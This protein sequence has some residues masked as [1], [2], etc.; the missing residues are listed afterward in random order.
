MT[1]SAAIAPGAPSP[2]RLR[3]LAIVSAVSVFVAWQAL[4]LVAGDNRAGDP[5]VPGPVDV[6]SAA[7]KLG[8]YWQGGLGIER[9]DQ[10]GELTWAGAALAFAYHSLVTALRLVVGFLI[11][12]VTGVVLAAL[13]SWSDTLR[14][15]VSL[16]AHG[17]RMLPLL[18]MIPLF[19][20]WFGNSNEGAVLFIGFTVFTFIFV[21]TITA[22]ANVPS[23]FP[24]YGQALGA[25]RVRV[26][27]R[28]VLPAAL[29]QL[30][31]G[32]ALALAFAWSA[33]IAAEYN[34]QSTGLGQI[35]HAAE[36]FS[37]TD[38]LAL[39]GLMVIGFAGL[40]FLIAHRAMSWVTRWAE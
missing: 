17:V 25:S 6:V 24:D 10:G 4:N 32:I 18:A 23:Y 15:M 21:F 13:V 12:L 36:E 27:V 8:N 37:Q 39:I 11:G 14:Q 5:L 7:K 28:I 29:P 3:A 16:V 38:T 19:G 2:A 33:V 34:G 1:A 9:T 20:L 30:R 35:A 31:S 40:S 26:Y 22:I